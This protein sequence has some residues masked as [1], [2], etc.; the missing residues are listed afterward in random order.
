MSENPIL[1]KWLLGLDEIYKII[2]KYKDTP[3][4]GGEP[5]FAVVRTQMYVLRYLQCFRDSDVP[6][7]RDQG[8]T[9]FF[10]FHHSNWGFLPLHKEPDYYDWRL[11]DGIA[12]ALNEYIQFLSDTLHSLP[13]DDRRDLVLTIGIYGAEYYPK[14]KEHF[15]RIRAL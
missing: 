12:T 7:E 4:S 6:S 5:A 2:N 15:A 13:A 3:G 1:K 10:S 9:N 11:A 8:Y 14:R